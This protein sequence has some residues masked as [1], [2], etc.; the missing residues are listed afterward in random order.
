MRLKKFEPSD[1]HR[2]KRRI[3]A[4]RRVV[5][6]LAQREGIKPW[7]YVEPMAVYE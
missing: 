1:A 3:G 4:L 7:G 2:Q 5:V 6:L